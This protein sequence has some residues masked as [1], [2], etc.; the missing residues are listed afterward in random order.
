MRTAYNPANWSPAFHDDPRH[1]ALLDWLRA[2]GI[3]PNR[4]PTNQVITIDNNR[5]RY[6]EYATDADGNK[7]VHN[8]EPVFEPKVSPL[9]I[10]LPP[11]LDPGDTP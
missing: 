3:D 2:N 7:L 6:V 1:T 8:N 4:L 11:E 5:V 9:V 10:D